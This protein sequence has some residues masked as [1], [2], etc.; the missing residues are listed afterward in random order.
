MILW[1]QPDQNRISVSKGAG[2]AFGFRAVF[3]RNIER[4]MAERGG[5]SPAAETRFSAE[6]EV[7]LIEVP[8]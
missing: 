3:M 4:V 1:I 6:R 2:G 7:A 5:C 8:P